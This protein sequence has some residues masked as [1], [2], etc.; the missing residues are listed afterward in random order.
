MLS[1]DFVKANDGEEDYPKQSIII[2]LHS[3]YANV[4]RNVA[5]FYM[6]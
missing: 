5:G 3:G 2:E 4:M 1:L 6:N